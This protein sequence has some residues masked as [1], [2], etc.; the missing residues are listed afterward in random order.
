MHGSV[1]NSHGKSPLRK[2]VPEILSHYEAIAAFQYSNTAFQ[3][4]LKL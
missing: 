1:F 4:P 2:V 3:W